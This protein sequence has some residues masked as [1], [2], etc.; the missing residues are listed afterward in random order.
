M[1]ALLPN[2]DGIA[3][4]KLSDRALEG[5]IRRHGAYVHPRL[6]E[7]GWVDLEALEALGHVEVLEVHPLPGEQVL[8][9]TRTGWAVLEVA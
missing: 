8:V 9:P 5:L 7:E 4:M 3:K 1:V 2:T 6:V